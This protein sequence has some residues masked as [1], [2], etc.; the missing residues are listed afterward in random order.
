MTSEEIVALAAQPRPVISGEYD[1][2][3]EQLVSIA[4][5]LL[6]G[7]IIVSVS[8]KD[9]QQIPRIRSLASHLDA[10]VTETQKKGRTYLRITPRAG[11]RPPKEQGSRMTVD[12]TQ[13]QGSIVIQQP[14]RITYNGQG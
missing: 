10:T 11:S 2:G 4:T 12:R 9:A 8:P 6:W 14:Y 1:R 7:L 5:S 3:T 13:G